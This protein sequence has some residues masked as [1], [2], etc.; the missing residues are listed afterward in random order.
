MRL[1]NTLTK[2]IEEFVP[3]DPQNVKIYTCGPT[4]YSFAHIGNFAAYIY[5]DLLIRTI[6]LHGW[7]PHRVMN[8]TDVGHLTSDGDEGDDKMEKG[9]KRENKTVWE[10]ADFY[11]KAFLTD[12]YALDLTEPTKIARA[13]DY[14]KQDMELVQSLINK[15]LTYETSDGIYFDTSKFSTYADFAKLNLN[16]LKA[17]ARV[18]FNP[19]K[20][21]ISDF[22]IWK[23]IK[24]GEDHAMKW[25]FQGRPGYPGWHLECSAISHAELGEPLDIHT[26]GIDHIPVHH[27]NEIAQSE[28]AFDRQMSR[29]WLHCYHITSEGQKLS[30]SL[31]NTYSIADLKEN[32]FSPLDYKM[33][34]LQGH[35]QSE[36]NFTLTDLG[37][38]KIRRLKWKNQIAELLQTDM[39]DITD[40]T[41]IKLSDQTALSG[42]LRDLL[43]RNSKPQTEISQKIFTYVDNN[44]NS[45]EA[46]SFIDQH[47]LTL[48]DWALIEN[49]FGIGLFKEQCLPSK[50]ILD[51][52]NNR[53]QARQQKD[54]KTADEIREKIEQTGYSVK[55][56]TNQPI[57]QYLK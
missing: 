44:L 30:K 16:H 19:E 36:R 54:Y 1:Y 32:G 5:W 18:E 33:W 50:E 21:N 43:K 37:S 38:T 45:A 52:I 12:F 23:F 25:D 26:G 2:K 28:V 56:R 57:W 42:L 27:T 7:I 48:D 22:A 8:V 6:K 40:I 13:T 14:I 11:T 24:D 47:Q 4:V 53:Q 39:T 17:G 34:V 9:A 15:G 3:Q 41:D 31:G 10:I 55:D 20:R 35:Y 29:F 49:L 51:L 46:F